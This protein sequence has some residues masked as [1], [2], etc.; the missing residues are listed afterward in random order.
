M[1]Q[2]DKNLLLKDIFSR[3]PYGVKVLCPDGE[4]AEL[5]YEKGILWIKYTHGFICSLDWYLEDLKLYLRSMSSMTEE[6]IKEAENI[7]RLK[8]ID[9]TFAELR[10]FTLINDNFVDWLNAHH[11]DYRGL[12]EKGLV[13]E[14]PENMYLHIEDMNDIEIM[15]K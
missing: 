13:L 15:N 1:T 14:A 7:S 5:F 2:E 12:I 6:E 8:Y 4:D 9:G 10:Q 11:F 3:L